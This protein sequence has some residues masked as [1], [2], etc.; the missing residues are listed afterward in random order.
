MDSADTCS[1]NSNYKLQTYRIYSI[2]IPITV[3]ILILESI[4]V[5]LNH[6]GQKLLPANGHHQVTPLLQKMISK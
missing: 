4:Y 1:P 6:P 2:I 3:G 5:F